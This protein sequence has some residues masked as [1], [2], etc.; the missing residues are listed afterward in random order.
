MTPLRYAKHN[1]HSVTMGMWNR[2]SP[3][4]TEDP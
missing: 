2:R 4:F 3:A 1:G